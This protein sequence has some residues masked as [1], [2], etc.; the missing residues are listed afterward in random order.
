MKI[1]LQPF[2][3]QTTISMEPCDIGIVKMLYYAMKE[4][5]QEIP[6]QL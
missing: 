4:K 6:G 2:T 3:K 1:Q 5:K